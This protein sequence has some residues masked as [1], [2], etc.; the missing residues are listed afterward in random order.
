[1]YSVPMAIVDFFPVMFFGVAIFILQ[2]DLYNKMSKGAYAMF[3]A[4]TMDVFMSGMLKALYK[5]LYALGVCDFKPLNNLFFP[6]QAIGFILAGVAMVCLIIFPQG[7]EKIYAVAAPVLFTGTMIFVVLM[8][9]G[10]LGLA[11]S[12]SVIAGRMRRKKIIVCFI[13]SFV[14]SLCMGYL[15]SK[16]FAQSYMNWAAEGVNIIGQGMLLVGV[17]KLDKA[18][19]EKFQLREK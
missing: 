1:M 12:L 13:I 14:F 17:L 3:C 11:A 15:S 9:T 18:G 7:K 10:L 5:L 19:L 2:R 6:L 8:I 16:D 4:G